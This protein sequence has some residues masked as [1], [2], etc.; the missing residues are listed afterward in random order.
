MITRLHIGVDISKRWFDVCFFAQ[1]EPAFARYENTT[2][3]ASRF[4]HSV[5]DLARKHHVCMEYTGGFE[6]MLALACKEAGFTVSLVD[7]AKI[8]YFRK[9]FSAS[10]SST[11]KGSSRLLALFCKQRKPAEWFPLPD[12]YRKL[13]ELVRHRQNMLEAKTE[14][15]SRAA[16]TVESELV[17]AQKRAMCEFLNLQAEQVEG[18]IRLHVSGHENLGREIAL[19]QTIPNVAFV[20]AFRILAETGPIANYPSAKEY[21]L[22]AGL[23]PIVVHSGQHVPPGKLGVYGNRE[24]R[25]AL[26]FPAVVSKGNGKG[27]GGFMAQVQANGSKLKMTVVAAGMRKLAHVVYGV[28]TSSQPYDPQKVQRKNTS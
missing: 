9:S 6:R 1:K 18:A 24:L 7:G 20:S 5:R 14:W 13:R 21:A 23:A 27:V 8:A 10:G 11:D 3:G 25:C 15:S 12:E 4:I 17:T 19:L 28:L 26:F 2:E 22:A 16:Y